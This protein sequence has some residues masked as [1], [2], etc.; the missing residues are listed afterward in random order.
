MRTA[1][2]ETFCCRARGKIKERGQDLVVG[3]RVNVM[4]P[5]NGDPV[6]EDVYPRKSQ[7][8]RPSVANVDQVVALMSVADPPLDL[9]LLDRIVVSVEAKQLGMILCLNKID[10]AAA[11]AREEIQRVKST[12]QDCSYRVVISSALSGQG[13]D[14]ISRYLDGCI[15]VLA[16]PSGVGKSTLINQ[17]IPGADLRVDA[18]SNKS[19][20][21]KH[22]TRAVELIPWGDTGYLVDTPGFQRLDLEDIALQDLPGCFPDITEHAGGCR[23]DDCLHEAEPHCAAKEA[24]QAGKLA[25]WRYRNYLSFLQEIKR[26]EQR[27]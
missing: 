20:R 23:F 17:L 21:G 15:T 14:T 25:P 27:Y 7:I 4:C 2:G 13:I 18:V 19:R 12:Y 8:H 11:A 22:T 1:N 26:K 3:D 10:L 24:L 9:A 5:E 6:I 16:G